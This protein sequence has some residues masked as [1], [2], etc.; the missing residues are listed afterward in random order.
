MFMR[1]FIIFITSCKILIT[2]KMI[3]KYGKIYDRIISRIF[4]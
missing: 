4:K 2:V 3:C 1:N